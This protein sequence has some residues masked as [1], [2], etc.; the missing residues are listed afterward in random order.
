MIS[1]Q[2]PNPIPCPNG[3]YSEF[4]GLRD[5]TDC[6]LCP[7]GNYCYSQNPQEQPITK[8][9]RSLLEKIDNILKYFIIILSTK[10]RHDM[11]HSCNF[12][13][14]CVLMDTFAP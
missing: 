6:F 11:K 9:V 12:S 1:E 14:E 5:V 7:E 10:S 2:D 4:P 3:T 8:P 13:Q